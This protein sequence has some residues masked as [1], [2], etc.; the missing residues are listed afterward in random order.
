MHLVPVIDL[1]GGQVVHARQ[2]D[3]HRYAPLH[4]PLCPS[5]E[6]CAL[7]AS[8]L[9]LHAFDCCYVADLDAITGSGDNLG[10]IEE[11]RSRWPDLEWWVDAG[12][13]WD[14][15]P[16]GCTPVLGT[17]S[18]RDLEAFRH[19]LDHHGEEQL[20]LSLDFR[21]R[22]FLGPPLLLQQPSIWPRRILAMNLLRVGTG[23]GPDLPLLRRLRARHDGLLYAAG[24]IRHRQ[25][26]DQLATDGIDGALVASAL[27]SGT[28][29]LPTADSR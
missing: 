9:E 26:L 12:S 8:L 14:V 5:A 16:T 29:A 23:S 2:G 27:H 6:P 10:I 20:V 18:F 13:A 28:L 3:R 19:A 25:D 11:L 24:G 15:L 22:A 1:L 21:D 17:E 4:S 7:V